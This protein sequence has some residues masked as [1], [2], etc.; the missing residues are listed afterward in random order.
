MASLDLFESTLKEVVQ[1]KRL[2]ARKMTELTE[3]ALKMMEHDTQL[4]SILYRTHKTLPPAAK[5]SSLYI[6]DALSRAAR[7]QVNKQGL[8]GSLYAEK[9]NCATF[10]LKVE[11]VLEGLFQDM[12]TIGSNGSKEKTQ[13]ILD[14]WVKG[15]TFPSTVL[16]RLTQLVKEPEKVPEVERVPMATLETQMASAPPN[17]PSTTVP[18]I[19]PQAALLALL[20]QAASAT[21]STSSE[22][23]LTNTTMPVVAP[24]ANVNPA[25]L[26]LLQQLAQKAISSPVTQTFTPAVVPPRPATDSPIPPFSPTGDRPQSP[27]PSRDGHHDDNRQSLNYE[28]YRSRS[29][30]R[31][32]GHEPHTDYHRGSYRGNFRARGRG[33]LRSRWDDR[34]RFR[35]RDRDRDRDWNAPRRNG[36]GRSRSPPGRYPNRRDMRPYSPPGRPSIPSPQRHGN[37]SDASR[38]DEKDEF[39]RDLRPQSPESM[40]TTPTDNPTNTTRSRSISIN[41]PA[42]VTSPASPSNEQVSMSPLVAANTSSNP[43]NASFISNTVPSQAGMENF[44]VTNFDPTSP[45]SWEL[46]GKMWQVTYGVTPSAEQL[47]QYIMAGGQAP[48]NQPTSDAQDSSWSGSHSHGQPRRGRGRGGSFRGRGTFHGHGNG[49]EGHGDWNYYDS[50]QTD[51]I[52]L[53]GDGSDTCDERKEDELSS[54]PDMGKSNGGKM[55]RV[56][57]KWVFVR[58]HEPAM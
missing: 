51:A 44:D 36:R 39:G 46:L 10:L 38:S 52:V 18:A 23:T 14:I 50:N 26:A 42:V 57:D 54:A 43:S 53:G 21:V 34:D 17:V 56:G 24:Q 3:I 22:Q 13:K 2:S 15:N 16:S 31:N 40:V 8:T 28:R 11:G 19:D 47:M 12:V 41:E 49:R 9:G 29:P 4:V 35:D 7:H 45:S 27:I 6:F 32:K 33:D 30:D 48:M 1:A 58:D 5:V 25:Q 55:Q 37:G 20:T